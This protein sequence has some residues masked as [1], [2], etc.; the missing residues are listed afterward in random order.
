M[1]WFAN[2]QGE[3]L[4]NPTN[5]ILTFNSLDA[6]K[7]GISKATVDTK[8]ELMTAMGINEWA[9]AG[10]KAR[11]NM[12]K[13]LKNVK[14]FEERI[15]SLWVEYQ[16]ALQLAN[17]GDEELRQRGVG[18]ARKVLRQ[19]RG[20]VRRAPSFEEYTIFTPEWFTERDQE[21]RDLARGR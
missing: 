1:K 12:L 16:I 13:F 3:H 6:E 10:L 20:L 9:E 21:L 19:M 14:M 2:T 7:Y 11:D 5:R 4:V 8:E 17:G 15:N 18:R